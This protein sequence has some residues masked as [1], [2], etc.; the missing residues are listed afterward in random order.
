MKTNMFRFSCM[1]IFLGV[2]HVTF[3]EKLWTYSL[4]LSR[5]SKGQDTQM[6]CNRIFFPC[7]FYCTWVNC[8]AKHCGIP[9]E[10][11]LIKGRWHAFCHRWNV[12]WAISFK[13]LA[14]S[15]SFLQE[16]WKNSACN[17]WHIICVQACNIGLDII[18]T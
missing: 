13:M 17:S 14:A 18:F 11:G 1:V 7:S 2:G 6:P 16:H 12:E 5:Q 10:T 9:H 4:R 15:G 3:L 8:Y